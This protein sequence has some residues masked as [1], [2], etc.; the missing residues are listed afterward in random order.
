MLLLYTGSLSWEFWRKKGV[1][2]ID[3][4]KGSQRQSRGW[5]IPLAVHLQ[6]RS[7]WRAVPTWRTLRRR[8]RSLRRPPSSFPSLT[9]R[10]SPAPR[11]RNAQ[12]PART[13]RCVWS[14]NIIVYMRRRGSPWGEGIVHRHLCTAVLPRENWWGIRLLQQQ[15]FPFTCLVR[16]LILYMEHPLGAHHLQSLV[17]TIDR[18]PTEIDL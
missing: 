4:K 10:P 16:R 5:D 1:R 3:P 11:P 15:W 9:W 6:S 14:D 7:V 17:V 18:E 12:A 8:R 13:R 2:M